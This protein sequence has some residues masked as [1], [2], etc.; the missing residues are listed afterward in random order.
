MSLVADYADLKV[1]AF[2]MKLMLERGILELERTGGDRATLT[3]MADA[4]EQYHQR[5]P[6]ERNIV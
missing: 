3:M 2:G 1:V 4:L 6:E 5:F